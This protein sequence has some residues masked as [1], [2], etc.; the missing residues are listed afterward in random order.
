LVFLAMGLGL[1]AIAYFVSKNN[2][3]TTLL[4]AAAV[5]LVGADQADEGEGF[6]N[7]LRVLLASQSR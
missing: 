7:S 4:Y 5:L 3:L 1:A 2:V 6:V